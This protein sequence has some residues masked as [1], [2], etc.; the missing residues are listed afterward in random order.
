MYVPRVWPREG[1]GRGGDRPIGLIIA[2]G[3]GCVSEEGR[4]RAGTG[5]PRARAWA[6]VCGV[7]EVL[8]ASTTTCSGGP[9]MLE[10]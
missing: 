3:V 4:A 6:V 9:T 2:S 10:G 5:V 8:S 1:E 7:S